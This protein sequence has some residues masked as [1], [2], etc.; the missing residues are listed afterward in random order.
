MAVI[1]GRANISPDGIVLTTRVSKFF[2]LIFITSLI[3][4]A[5]L[6]MLSLE[7]IV[8]KS[9]ISLDI[10]DSLLNNFR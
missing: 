8:S 10:S 3:Q 5:S 4:L 7:G 2:D 6:L 9:E 1:V